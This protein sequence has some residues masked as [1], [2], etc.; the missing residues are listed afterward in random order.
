[1]S[2]TKFTS[3]LLVLAIGLNGCAMIQPAAMSGPCRDPATG[4]YT[5]CSTGSTGPSSWDR[6]SSDDRLA[7]GLTIGISLAALAAWGIYEMA[8]GPSR[9]NIGTPTTRKDTDTGTTC[10]DSNGVSVLLS[11][12]F[13][14]V[15]NG[16]RSTTLTPSLPQGSCVLTAQQLSEHWNCETLRI[17]GQHI[18]PSS[19]VSVGQ[20]VPT[21]TTLPLLL[22]PTRP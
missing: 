20:N 19:P 14:C 6:L 13:D 22:S 1:M 16:Y 2:K 4:R 10:L 7:V 5:S 18:S 3:A 17:F 15:A 21:T 12:N 9:V 8:S 11:S